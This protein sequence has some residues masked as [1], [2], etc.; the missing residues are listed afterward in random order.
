MPEAETAKRATGYRERFEANGCLVLQDQLS[1]ATVA[2]LRAAADALMADGEGRG[3]G[4]SHYDFEPETL[5]GRAVIQRIKR[6]HEI[7]PFFAE[8]ARAPEIL[9]IVEELIGPDIRL[10]HS[11]INVKMPS[12]GSPLEWHQDWAFVPHTNPSMAFVSIAIDACTAENGPL[13]LLTGTHLTGLRDH[14]H[15]GYFFGAIDTAAEGVDTAAAETLI[16]APG[17]MSV[18]HPL[19]IHGSGHNTST[20]PRRILFFEYAAADAWPLFYGVDWDEYES[21]MV[22]GKSSQWPRLS[23]TP[24]RMPYPRQTKGMIYDLQQQFT[25]RFFRA[26]SAKNG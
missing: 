9:D 23:D 20:G 22:R 24:I 4:D 19:I 3:P 11:K 16:G 2:R 10:H 17:A 25:K 14:H 7:S 12:V 6:P 5:N 18:H 13:H 21:R 1:A 26:D 15:D 8:L